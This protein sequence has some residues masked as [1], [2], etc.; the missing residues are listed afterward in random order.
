LFELLFDGHP[1][2]REYFGLRDLL[3]AKGVLPPRVQDDAPGAGPRNFVALLSAKAE[4]E[5]EGELTA[6]MD[7]ARSAADGTTWFPTRKPGVSWRQSPEAVCF[8]F[9]RTS[10]RGIDGVVARV[11]ERRE[12]RP[13]DP[14][15]DATYVGLTGF[16]AWWRVGRP[17]RVRLPS[18]S[19]LPGVTR[20]GNAAVVAFTGT[21][22][23][24]A[25]WDFGLGFD[26]LIKKLAAD[27]GE[28]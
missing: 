16:G 11:L 19:S 14:A 10:E 5:P 4:P 17:V 6:I 8:I 1:E 7:R 3:A 9:R 22:L 26:D 27:L 25:Y 23:S 18:I 28:K 20:A 12:E 21:T 2:L 24:F 15:L 13:Q